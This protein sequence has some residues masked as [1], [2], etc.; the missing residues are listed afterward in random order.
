MLGAS[1]AVQLLNISSASSEKDQDRY[2]SL[3]FRRLF[4]FDRKPDVKGES[5][6]YKYEKKKVI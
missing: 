4:H 3:C 1:D 2:K 6:I 5:E